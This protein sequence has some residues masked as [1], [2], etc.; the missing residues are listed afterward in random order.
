MKHIRRTILLAVLL[1]A[2]GVSNVYATKGTVTTDGVRV[3]KEPNTQSEIVTILNK[4]AQVDILEETDGWYRI[5]YELY[6]TYE[7]YMK[8]DFI[9]KAGEET[10][11][12]TT[13]TVAPTQTPEEVEKTPTP[14]QT[15]MPEVI[16]TPSVELPNDNL[17]GKKTITNEAQIYILPTVTASIKDKIDKN[18]NVEVL[19]VAGNFVYIK[20][21]NQ[22]GWIKSNLLNSNEQLKDENKN[23]EIENEN[24]ENT[25]TTKNGYVN[26]EQ[27]IVREKATTSSSMVTSLKLNDEVTIIGEKGEFYKIKIDNSECYIAK[28]LISDTKQ[29]TN[30]S[31][32]SR[33]EKVATT[34]TPVIDATPK[35]VATPKTEST[36]KIQKTETPKTTPSTS[37][38]GEQIAQ[39]A[40]DYVGYK[41][42]Y[43]GASPSTGFDCS[44]LVYY[45]CGQL[46]YKVNR[47]ADYQVNNGVEVRKKD[48]QLGDLVF[49]TNY[50]TNEG[51][52]HV[53]IYIGNNQF[54]HASTSSTGV[55]ISS[56]SETMYVKRYVTAR[57]IG[58]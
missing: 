51:I 17:L 39:M 16:E 4:S 32:I 43:G 3:R 31:G 45:I 28:R 9:K 6:G 7:G 8:K 42:V 37:S 19:E 33:Q 48:L 34:P 18:T 58:V 24:K 14:T 50:R 26:V 25:Y 29:T 5:K 52:G 53:G 21:N 15:D 41:Y 54:V 46:G 12:T 11:P 20:C 36:Q 2:V 10:V 30:R 1:F 13:P 38:V 44:G 27:A 22:T 55:I 35:A 56:L 57:R 23:N 47:T 40:Q 49:F